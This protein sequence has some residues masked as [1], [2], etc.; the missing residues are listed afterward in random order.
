[1][2]ESSTKL[3]RINAQQSRLVRAF[4]AV[5][6][7]GQRLPDPL[8]LFL[9]MSVLVILVSALFAGTSADVV[10]R[11]GCSKTMTV[12]S[13]LTVEGLRW[14]LTSAVKNFIEFAPLG[15]V[16]TVMIG[17]GVAERTGFISMGLKVLVTRVPS[18]LLTATVVF[19]GVMSSMAADAGYVVLTPLGALLFASVKRHPLA[20]LAAAHAGV[21]GGFSANLLITGLDPMLAKLTQQAAQTL[22]PAYTVNAACNYYFMIASTLLVTVVGTLV[23][24]RIVE[25][26]LGEWDPSQ[27]E[28]AESAESQEPGSSEAR[29]FMVSMGVGI[30][31][32]IGLLLLGLVPGAPLTMKSNQDN[33]PSTC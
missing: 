23:T 30:A 33:R 5:E 17:I 24:T 4:G 12:Q 9:L 3:R 32:G 21:S 8:T 26:M 15:P 20:G 6:R 19:A 27:G 16:L 25:P 14:M 1:M 18:T 10:Q 7:V 31:V 22:D 11:S 2:T 13:L 28:H 29:A